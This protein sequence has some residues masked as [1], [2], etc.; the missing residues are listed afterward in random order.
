MPLLSSQWPSLSHKSSSPLSG[1]EN[2]PRKLTSV[3]GAHFSPSSVLICPAVFN[4]TFTTIQN[5]YFFTS[6]LVYR[7][8]RVIVDFS[9]LLWLSSNIHC[10]QLSV[11]TISLEA[12]PASDGT[13]WCHPVVYLDYRCVTAVMKDQILVSPAIFPR[14]VFRSRQLKSSIVDRRMTLTGLIIQ[15]IIEVAMPET[16]QTRGCSIIVKKF[17]P[18]NKQVRFFLFFFKECCYLQVL[19]PLREVIRFRDLTSFYFNHHRLISSE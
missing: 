6:F 19:S 10:S 2:F 7:S 4:N 14:C 12:N 18:Q 17:S 13:N 8:L 3:F 9:G 11:L 5:I 15:K 1:L 16:K